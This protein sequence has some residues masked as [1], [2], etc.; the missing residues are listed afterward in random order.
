MVMIAFW[1]AVATF[2]IPKEY[3]KICGYISIG[4]VSLALLITVISIFCVPLYTLNTFLYFGYYINPVN[5]LFSVIPIRVGSVG[6]LFVNIIKTAVYI[7]IAFAGMNHS[8]IKYESDKEFEESSENTSDAVS[9]SSEGKLLR[10]IEVN[11]GICTGTLRGSVIESKINQVAL[12]GWKFEQYE[13]IVG[14]W[15]LIFSRYKM[16]I[17]FSKEE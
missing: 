15:C 3:K 17:C 13:T 8:V 6:L 14:R 9:N 7:A 10:V 11:A 2:F 16:L 1:L 5:L 12:Q 4:I